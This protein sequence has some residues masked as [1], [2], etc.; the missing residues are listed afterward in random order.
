VV[1]RIIAVRRQ[2]GRNEPDLLSMFLSARDEETGER[3][4]DRHLRDEVMTMLLAGH[5]TTSL[6]L[7]WTFLLLSQH[8]DVERRLADE[9]ESVVGD[10]RAT[11]ADAER[12]LYTRMVLD[13]AMRLY[14][15]A[16]G[17]S[18]LALGD[19]R[20]GG[21]DVPAGSIVFRT[22]HLDR[23]THYSST[24]AGDPRRCGAARPNQI[25]GV[26]VIVV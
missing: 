16:W 7:S 9:A 10:R 22:T 6:A 1:Y 15:P 24:V 11:F 3:M 25:A 19:D 17:F 21:Y 26:S 18:R 14:P 23:P 5:E 12:L 8:E 13:E 20:L 4:T 2:S